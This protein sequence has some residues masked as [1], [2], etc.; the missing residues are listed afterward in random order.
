[1]LSKYKGPEYQGV[2]YN[3]MRTELLAEVKGH[4]DNQ[5]KE[6]FHKHARSKTGYVLVSDGWT[7][8]NGRPLINCVLVPTG[9]HFIKSVDCSGQEKNADFLAE[10]AIE[11]IEH[12]GP[13]HIVLF[14]QDGTSANN[15]ARAQVEERFPQIH[16]FHCTAHALGLLIEDIG[17]I[18]CFDDMIHNAKAIVSA[19]T[20]PEALR[21]AFN[22]SSCRSLEIHASTQPTS[23]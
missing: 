18:E 19:I 6:T 5:L 22:I 17:K 21:A 20:G 3:A 4:L 14:I 16:T 11:V 9:S 1:M 23:C 8:V 7:D 13:A 2:A 10:I 15:A 12:V